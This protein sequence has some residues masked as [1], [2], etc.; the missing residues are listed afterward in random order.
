MKR[1]TKEDFINHL[2]K[3]KK[4][5]TPE[6]KSIVDEMFNEIL[7]IIPQELKE[8]LQNEVYTDLRNLL[9]DEVIK[10]IASDFE[11]AIVWNS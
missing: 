11:G 6:L 9:D 2:Q 10:K 4:N 8:P 7:D 3:I 1:K 5:L